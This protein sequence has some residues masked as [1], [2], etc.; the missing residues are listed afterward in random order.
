VRE[1]FSLP[2][3]LTKRDAQAAT[4]MHLLEKQPLRA[5]TPA[6]VQRPPQPDATAFH[7]IPGA[8]SMTADRVVAQM[9]AGQGSSADLSE[10]QQSLVDFANGLDIPVSARQRVLQLARAIDNEHDAAVHVRDIATTFVEA[11]QS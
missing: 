10:F 9:A 4:L 2:S 5:N 8:A 1:L 3:S 6:T 11:A 7:E